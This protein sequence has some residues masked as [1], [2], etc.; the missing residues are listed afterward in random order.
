[1]AKPS[2]ANAFT[3]LEMVLV[4]T[5]VSLL[6]LV[7]VPASPSGF[8]LFLKE[9]ESRIVSEQIQAYSQQTTRTL[10]ITGTALITEND[11]F[12][13]PDGFGCTPFE[14]HYT[15]NGTISTAGTISCTGAGQSADLVFRLGAGRIHVR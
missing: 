7:S 15:P 4:L 2:A 6:G 3:L 10:S 9:L 11:T 1:M 13:F 8:S 5:M 14:W 12:V